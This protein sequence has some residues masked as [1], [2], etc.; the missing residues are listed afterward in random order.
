MIGAVDLLCPNLCLVLSFPV[1]LRSCRM[2]G[3]Q[4]TFAPL[5]WSVR[6]AGLDT[7][8]RVITRSRTA[9]W[10]SIH[11]MHSFP[12]TAFHRN[13][14][15]LALGVSLI[16][17][18]RRRLVIPQMLKL[19][20]KIPE[21]VCL[22]CSNISLGARCVMDVSRLTAP[23]LSCDARSYACGTARH[24]QA[25]SCVRGSRPGHRCLR[26]VVHL[27]HPA[28][29]KVQA[30]SASEQEWTVLMSTSRGTRQ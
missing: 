1:T 10:T 19:V 23:A 3:V 9:G 12:S 27:Q 22:P 6:Y 26:D 20:T 18:Y 30:I 14:L 16:T 17:F 2:Y 29:P 24:R 21:R 25:S 4:P 28:Q 15:E 11:H 8:R 13:D 5:L 7:G